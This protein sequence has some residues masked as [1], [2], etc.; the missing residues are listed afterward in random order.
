MIK[1][2]DPGTSIVCAIHDVVG[3]KMTVHAEQDMMGLV[4]SDIDSGGS[5]AIMLDADDRRALAA[6]LLEGL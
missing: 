3:G 4:V 2:F 1:E 6:A 5:A